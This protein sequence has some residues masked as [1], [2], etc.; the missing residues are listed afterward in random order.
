MLQVYHESGISWD[1]L[2][3]DIRDSLLRVTIDQ[4]IT[5]NSV[6]WKTMN[7][8]NNEWKDD[9]DIEFIYSV[10]YIVCRAIN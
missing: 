2:S 5:Q 9:I 1:D 6:D 7:R 3:D 4:N 10:G 8:F